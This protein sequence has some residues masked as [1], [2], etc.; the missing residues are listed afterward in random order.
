MTSITAN[1]KRMFDFLDTVLVEAGKIPT[2]AQREQLMLNLGIPSL[3]RAAAGS[4][5]DIRAVRKHLG[6]P[7]LNKK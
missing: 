7:G 4:E 3:E 1:P 6:L 5:S 2:R